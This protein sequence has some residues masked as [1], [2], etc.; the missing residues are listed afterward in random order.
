M[1]ILAPGTPYGGGA[2]AAFVTP[3]AVEDGDCC[4]LCATLPERQRNMRFRSHDHTPAW[5]QCEECE[6]W[7]HRVCDGIIDPALASGEAR[8][9]R[10]T[11]HL[12]KLHSQTDLPRYKSPYITCNT[13]KKKDASVPAKKVDRAPQGVLVAEKVRQATLSVHSSLP[14]L[15]CARLPPRSWLRVRDGPRPTIRNPSCHRPLQRHGDTEPF[16]VS[17]GIVDRTYV[18]PSSPHTSQSHQVSSL[19]ASAACSGTAGGFLRPRRKW[20]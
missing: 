13:E 19:F 9:K 10:R 4:D 3:D 12:P 8:K 18:R 7:L 11:L 17:K 5:V 15:L 16:V 6:K 14:N 1:G 2:A 20:K